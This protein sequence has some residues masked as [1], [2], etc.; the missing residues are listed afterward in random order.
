MSSYFKIKSITDLKD[1]KAGDKLHESDFSLFTSDDKFVQYEFV[2]MDSTAVTQY[3]V[4]AGIFTIGTA[5]QT[6]VLK[7]SGFTEQTV[8]EEYVST[9]D[10][11]DKIDTFFNKLDVYKK[12]GMDPKRAMLLYGPPGMGKSVTLAKVCKEY[13]K[14]DDTTI[15]IWPSDKFEAR[16]V[17]DFLKRFDYNTNKIE[18]LFLI[19][20]DLGGVENADGGRRYSESSLLSLLDNVERTFTIPTMIL[21]TT[22]YPENFLE[23]LVNRPQRFDDVIEVKRPTPEFRAKFLEFFSQGSATESAKEAIKDRKYDNFSVAHTKEVVI[24]SAL[25]DITLEEAMVSLLAQSTKATKGF[26]NSR[27]SVGIGGRDE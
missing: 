9:K 14:R 21:A 3:P 7:Q 19:I 13:A 6:M 5:G 24:R 11:S 2:D 27:G 25:Y 15:V 17:K 26:T 22:N 10:I 18:K 20:E 8:L 12:Y 16:H 23:N 4:K 1:A